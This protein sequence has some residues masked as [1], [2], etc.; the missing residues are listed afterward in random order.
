MIKRRRIPGLVALAVLAAP[1]VAAAQ[2][3]LAA[4]TRALVDAFQAHC[5]ANLAD[6][7]GLRALAAARG[8]APVPPAQLGRLNAGEA[9]ILPT[10]EG[11]VVLGLSPAGA[12]G[13]STRRAD[14]KHA[15]SLLKR[16]VALRPVGP[17]ARA[18]S[19][20]LVR[21]GREAT[22]RVAG[23]TGEHQGAVSLTLAPGP[24]APAAAATAA[25]P[26]PAGG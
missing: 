19:F 2:A 14:P 9:W 24:P 1:G 12:C 15:V 3:E 23:F 22:L 10:P 13:T 7:D 16:R 8:Y 26:P 25:L 20:R 4:S 11:E 18:S 6:F 17:T 21:G 5:L